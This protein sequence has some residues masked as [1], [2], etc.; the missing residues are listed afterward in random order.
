MFAL[1]TSTPL[2]KLMAHLSNPNHDLLKLIIYIYIIMINMYEPMVSIEVTLY[3]VPPG[4]SPG[5]S[6]WPTQA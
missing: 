3:L 4:S 6:Q 1:A 2:K 5:S